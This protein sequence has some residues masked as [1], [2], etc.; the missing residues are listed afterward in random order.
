MSEMN[1]MGLKPEERKEAVRAQ[2]REAARILARL[3]AQRAVSAESVEMELRMQILWL[4][5]AAN[6]WHQASCEEAQLLRLREIYL[7]REGAAQ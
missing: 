3:E 6:Q 4:T 2:L 1:A 5:N 7:R